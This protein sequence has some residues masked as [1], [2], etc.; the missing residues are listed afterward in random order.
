MDSE[1]TPNLNDEKMPNK[2]DNIQQI[3][4]IPPIP[5][6]ANNNPNPNSSLKI[7]TMAFAA[8]LIAALFF[9]AGYYVRGGSQ[10]DVIKSKPANTT[11]TQSKAFDPNYKFGDTTNGKLTK[12]P[13]EVAKLELQSIGL[14][15]KQNKEYPSS[16]N[17]Y[18]SQ[19]SYKYGYEQEEAGPNVSCPRD[20]GSFSYIAYINQTTGKY[21]SFGLY[22]CAGS[23][24][25]TVKSVTQADI[26]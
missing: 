25:S 22:Y 12:T 14:Y 7:A 11:S 13:D 21:D 16:E 9:A 15:Y 6:P 20:Y 2:P 19:I 18:M 4:A 23:D 3:N 17:Q 1:Q 24:G 10:S 8:L 5:P 26:K